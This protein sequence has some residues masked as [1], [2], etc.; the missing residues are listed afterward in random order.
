MPW[1]AGLLDKRLAELTDRQVGQL[2]AEHV[3][4][5]LGIFMPEMMICNQATHR[6]FR[7]PG[8]IL[9]PEDTEMQSKHRPC[10]QCGEDMMLVIG[11]DEP[12]YW[13][14]TRIKCGYKEH[15]R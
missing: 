6:L 4:H 5:D 3:G 14:C 9:T 2:L 1:V 8:G 13:E 12:D 11:I 15:I 7:S 10:P